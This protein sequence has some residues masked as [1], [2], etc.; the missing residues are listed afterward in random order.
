MLDKVRSAFWLSLW[1][2]DTATSKRSAGRLALAGPLYRYSFPK[3]SRKQH[4]SGCCTGYRFF[5]YSNVGFFDCFRYLLAIGYVNCFWSWLWWNLTLP[6][7]WPAFDFFSYDEWVKV[8]SWWSTFSLFLC[9]CQRL[10]SK[11]EPNTPSFRSFL[12][13][14]L[15][16]S[17]IMLKYYNIKD[18][19]M[20]ELALLLASIQATDYDKL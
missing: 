12:L 19:H 7:S 15:F 10:F 2:H 3:Y 8:W 20:S 18:C 11:G 14:L 1:P 9:C 16:I 5:P 17:L 13:A 6:F 4:I